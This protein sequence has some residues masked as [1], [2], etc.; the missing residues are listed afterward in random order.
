MF[1]KSA[2]FG[3]ELY[4]LCTKV[5]FVATHHLQC[6]ENLCFLLPSLILHLYTACRFNQTIS[7]RIAIFQRVKVLKFKG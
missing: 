1:L 7:E 2:W 5:G 6:R 3:N 4:I